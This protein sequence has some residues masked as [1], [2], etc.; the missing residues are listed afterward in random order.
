[1]R[2]REGVRSTCLAGPPIPTTDRADIF[3][4]SNASASTTATAGASPSAGMYLTNE[5]FLY[6]VVDVAVNAA[7]AT[8]ALEDCFGLDVV[9]V[10]RSEVRARRLRIVAPCDTRAA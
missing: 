5:A 2:A 3:P 4:T 6:R 1:M 10:P 7:G 8:V 9:R